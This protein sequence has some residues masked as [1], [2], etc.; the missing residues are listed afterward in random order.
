MPI[1]TYDCAKCEHRWDELV[2]GP[3]EIPHECPKCGAEDGADGL[4]IITESVS[5][6]K[7][8]HVYKGSGF[9]VNDYKKRGR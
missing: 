4:S 1:R 5:G 3:Q 9:Y 8:N 6:W 7:P 2:R